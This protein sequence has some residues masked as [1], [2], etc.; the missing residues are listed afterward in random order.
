MQMLPIGFL[1]FVKIAVLIQK[2]GVGSDF[3]LI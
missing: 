3:L 2:E 1:K